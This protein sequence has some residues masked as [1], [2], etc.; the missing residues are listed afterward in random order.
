MSVLLDAPRKA[1]NV[2][3][4]LD[5]SARVTKVRAR[6]P[7]CGSALPVAARTSRRTAT[8]SAAAC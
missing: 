7:P 1:P 3:A 5:H 8:R 6:A 4:L 2:R